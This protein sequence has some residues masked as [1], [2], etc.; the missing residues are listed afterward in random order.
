M[1]IRSITR[2][3]LGAVL[4]AHFLAS[5]PARAEKWVEDSFEDFAGGRLDA[6]GQNIYVARDGS[7]RTIHR[8]DINQDGYIDLM[9]NCTHDLIG[10]LPSTVAWM[11][12]ERKAGHA[13]LAVE[14]SIAVA[15]GDLNRDGHLDAVFCPNRQGVQNPRRFVTII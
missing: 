14:G 8:F 7:V 13:P 12:P 3:L 10:I 2:A 9:F 11:D 5:G 6:G 4:L 15:L 1:H